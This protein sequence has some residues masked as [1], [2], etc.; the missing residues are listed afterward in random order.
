M[1]SQKTSRSAFLLLTVA[2][3]AATLLASASAGAQTDSLWRTQVSHPLTVNGY[4]LDRE[5]RSF[6]LPDD[7][8]WSPSARTRYQVI[9][10]AGPV[11]PEWKEA[12]VGLG[13]KIFDYLPDYGFVARVP[14]STLRAIRGLSYVT[15]V[16]PF[17]P[18]FRLDRG[19]E[20]KKDR[21]VTVNIVLFEGESVEEVEAEIESLGGEVLKRSSYDLQ[22][23]IPRSTL[24]KI[25]TLEGIRWV[26]EA[27]P[28]ELRN[29]QTS[30]KIQ[31]GV[32]GYRPIWDQGLR[33]EGQIIGVADSGID[34]DH[35]CFYDPQH[36]QVQYTNKGETKPP[37][38][39][40]RKIVNY[41]RFVN[42]GQ[43]KSDHGTHVTG[44]LACD[45]TYIT[46]NSGDP[47]GQGMAPKARLSFT[48]LES[49][50]F[51]LPAVSDV[52]LIF[53]NQYSD[54]ARIHSDSWGE[55]NQFGVYTAMTR[56]MDD[57]MWNHKDFLV[58]V[59][60]GN[61]GEVGPPATAKSIVSVGANVNSVGPTNDGRIK[62]T[63]V[64]PRSITSADN[65]GNL[66]TFNSG[67]RGMSGTSMATPAV[68]GG[69]ALV[70]QYF[71]G[72]WYPEGR[73]N[74][75]N[76]FTPSAALLKAVLLAGTVEVTT[77]DADYLNEGKFPNNTQGWGFPN[78]EGSLHF[79][80]QRRKLWVIDQTQG[81][82]T[83][84]QASFTV[85]V[86]DVTEPFRVVLVWTDYPGAYGGTQIL[87]NDL[88]LR[89][90]GP[91]GT[92]YLGNVTQGLNPG[93]S[94][95]GG[96]PD[97]VN[98]EEGVFLPTSQYGLMA[99]TYTLTV[100]AINVP[101]GPQPYALVV[102]GGLEGGPID[103]ERPE[104]ESTNPINGAY[105]VPFDTTPSITF[106][107][108]MSH[109]S[110]ANAFSIEPVVTG[111]FAWN[112]PTLTFTPSSPLAE[113]TRYTV[114]VSTA[115]MDLA[116]NPLAS[117]FSFSFT[118]A[119]TTP[120][121]NPEPPKTPAM[122]T[123]PAS[124]YADTVYSYFST[125]TD[126][127][128]DRIQYVFDWGDGT[129]TTSPFLPSGTQA[130]VTHTWIQSGNFNV[131]VQA[132][133][134]TG[135]ESD[136]SVP[137]VVS[138]SELP[139]ALITASTGNG[140]V[141]ISTR[142][143]DSQHA[144]TFKA[145]VSSI[146]SVSLAL[147]KVGTL[148]PDFRI[149]VSIRSYQTYPDLGYG[150]V[151]PQDV[152]STD[153]ASPSWTKV[154][155]NKAISLT[156][157]KIYYLVLRS[158]DAA[159]DGSYQWRTSSLNPYRD[160][161]LYTGP[162]W[163]QNPATDALMRIPTTTP[164][165]NLPPS[166][167]GTIEGPSSG[168][169]GVSYT[170]RTLAHDADGDPVRIVFDWGDGRQTTTTQVSS[171]TM[172]EVTQAWETAGTYP[173]R[174]KA[175][176]SNGHESNW[177]G[178]LAVEIA[179][180][181]TTSP[182]IS[183]IF[184]SS[185]TSSSALI[186]WVTDELSSSSVEYGPSS[187]YGSTASGSSPVT[188]HSVT[189]SDLLPD[190]LYHFRVLSQDTAGNVASS[191][192]S[193]FRTLPID[194]S[195]PQISDVHARYVTATT[196][197]ITWRTDEASTSYVD[198]GIS[199][200]YGSTQGNGTLTTIHSVE[201]GPLT[202]NTLYHYQVRSADVGSYE[203]VGDDRTFTTRNEDPWTTYHSYQGSNSLV[204]ELQRL[205]SE[206][207]EIA[208]L[209]SMG[210]TH[211][212]REL[213]ALK[214]SDNVADDEDE[215]EMLMDGGFHGDEWI[216]SETAT[217]IAYQLVNG[218]GVDSDITQMVN[219][220]EIWVIPLVNPDGRAI[221]S[222]DDGN[223]PSYYRG[224]R[225]NARDNN[226]SGSW[227]GCDGVDLNRNFDLGWGVGASTSTCNI[228]Y[229]GPT[230]FSE[231]ESQAFRN[232]V[233]SRDFQIYVSYHSYGRRIYY[234][235][236]YQ[237][238]LTPDDARFREVANE[239]L[240]YLPDYSA[241]RAGSYGPEGGCS[242]DWMYQNFRAMA[243]TIEV[244]LTDRPDPSEILRTGTAHLEAALHLLNLA[245]NPW[246]EE[247][248]PPPTA[249]VAAFTASVTSGFA[250]LE[251]QFTDQSTG[252]ISSW[253][254]NF[255]DGAT[256]NERDPV[257]TYTQPGDYTV[258]LTVTGPGGS[259]T[260]TLTNLIQVEEAPSAP[261]A[262]FTANPTTGTSPLQVQFTD[263]STGT[264]SSWSWNFGDGST[265]SEKDP[266]HTYAQA[267][268]Y[269]VSLTVSG[270]GG[271]DTET[272]TN[273]IHV[274][275]GVEPE[276]LVV[277]IT[278]WLGDA[279]VYGNYFYRN[280][281]VSY[282]GLYNNKECH[283]TFWFSPIAIPQGAQIVSAWIRV[284]SSQDLSS[285]CTAEVVGFAEDYPA[286][287]SSF[288]DWQSRPRTNAAVLWNMET[289][290]KEKWYS[291]PELASI[292][293]EIIDR[294]GWKSGH[295]LAFSIGPESGTANF[296]ALYERD[297]DYFYGAELIIDYLP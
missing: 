13:V 141:V 86:T 296:R 228:E 239:L 225:K 229:I 111:T 107:E 27:R 74:L 70:R 259:D 223:N 146:Q 51:P 197:R 214:I 9:Q 100:E 261:V 117:P 240:T 199:S 200:S 11:K 250:P 144:Q 160:G 10:F 288:S 47:N 217:F 162:T 127:N 32:E 64:A 292:V 175:I 35:E 203:S 131:H 226:N 79:A 245:D 184:V 249:P 66:G 238:D 247:P 165:P 126:S 121:P 46:N 143:L 48:D 258:S 16:G 155:F 268:D 113:R 34:W 277:R 231:P 150:Y 29:S 257:Y 284:P 104:V 265:S 171:G 219:E 125:T 263:Q 151:H 166:V 267:G 40:H 274:D 262:S 154:T 178:I 114:T 189:L 2:L 172:V 7:L 20:G 81:L 99:G 72:G 279:F 285:A 76:A 168:V 221:D 211:Q 129:S 208:Q 80:G 118:S 205:A 87:V 36:P 287:V 17:E 44:T 185:L 254:W 209:S 89:V 194:V 252:T 212:G 21:D 132:I 24:R 237:S 116:G 176:D 174:A 123:G 110:V 1:N 278:S 251:V 164:P 156:Q 281:K 255:G 137:L 142:Y 147:A 224:W 54:T 4:S 122:P 241:V 136:V 152:I 230:S 37:D 139:P 187:S 192:D 128:G 105:D 182:Q 167:P 227:D 115:A 106:S 120:G 49:N 38:L 271:N 270:A 218:Y 177:G 94:V 159:A 45:N 8:K 52:P 157:G 18:A 272:M 67:Y 69:L 269:T 235:W 119:G 85:T 195:P 275:Q 183:N 233:N 138:V 170:F 193:T 3:A 179:G 242:D 12:L 39:A 93:H 246:E 202:L 43:D 91:S 196:A 59:A 31:S 61:Q 15:Y 30:W 58:L 109:S 68:A 149:L 25:I 216:G 190:A 22:A 293:Q 102:V 191:E 148:D 210:Q 232:F 291:T 108:E 57:Y 260:E 204:T 236:G 283:S 33:G 53:D 98:V 297:Q 135:R 88:D 280:N 133:D 234:P 130:E 112:G 101:Q 78:L 90:Q 198:F 276:R 6:S 158:Y 84:G 181:D 96:N 188:S 253:S 282:I 161:M 256:S 92:T 65:D 19:L 77:E 173:V 294:A 60:N 23:V 42:D 290:Q 26:E 83:G 140:S 295:G 41:W 207:P 220:R 50:Y 63:V 5:S 206:F 186:S 215:P 55:I 213:W 264:I 103:T 289:W 28:I 248:P 62:P 134:E 244:A 56:V 145:P 243:F 163:K 180:E 14:R 286:P 95:T 201:I 71:M 273:L 73:A 222:Y 153:P 97:R 82:N 266:V 169:I 75:A 124:C